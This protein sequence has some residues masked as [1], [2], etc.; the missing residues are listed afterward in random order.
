MMQSYPL[1]GAI[2][3][4]TYPAIP[5]AADATKMAVFAVV[6]SAVELNANKVMKIDMVNPM[7]A[8]KPAPR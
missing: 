4:I 1:L 3:I 5:A 7:P 8:N 2:L 6:I